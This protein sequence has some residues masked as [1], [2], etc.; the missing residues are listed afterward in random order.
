MTSR[1]KL[2]IENKTVLKGMMFG[3]FTP[4]SC[5]KYKLP[6]ILVTRGVIIYHSVILRP[7]NFRHRF[8]QVPSTRV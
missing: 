8:L 6:R 5:A 7:Q 1:I 3:T 2:D 4:G